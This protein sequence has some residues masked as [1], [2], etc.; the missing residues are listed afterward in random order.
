MA[1]MSVTVCIPSSRSATVVHAVAER[2]DAFGPEADLEGSSVFLWD[3]WVVR[4]GRD[5]FGFWPALGHEGDPRLIRTGFSGPGSIQRDWSQLLNLPAHCA[6]GPRS[7]LDLSDRP[8]CLRAL[9]MQTWDVWQSLSDRLPPALTMSQIAD[10]YRISPRH[11]YDYKAAE[12][13]FASQPL[14]H[15]FKQAHPVGGRDRLVYSDEFVFHPDVMIRCAADGREAFVDAAAGPKVGA[16]S[17]LTLDGWWVEPDG[18][19]YHGECVSSSCSH[20][21][22]P[23]AESVLQFGA[24]EAKLRYLR[25][26]PGDVIVVQVH[27]HC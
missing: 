1:G 20:G 5:D 26:L 19:A 21:P 9:A 14:V 10:R 3:S 6:G 15:A 18:E 8:A 2:L 23:Y 22:H 17:L 11:G 24:P 4:G 16:G 7:L 25:E 12:A 13:E 27:G